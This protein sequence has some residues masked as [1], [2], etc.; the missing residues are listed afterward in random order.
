MSGRINM[1]KKVLY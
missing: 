1:G